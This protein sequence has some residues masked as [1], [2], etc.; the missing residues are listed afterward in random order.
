MG[1]WIV[2]LVLLVAAA[3]EI[4]A[5]SRNDKRRGRDGQCD[6]RPGVKE[7]ILCQVHYTL[8]ADL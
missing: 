6:K 4:N 3:G 1:R 5:R 2:E 7:Q 8:T